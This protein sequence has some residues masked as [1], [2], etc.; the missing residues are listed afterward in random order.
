MRNV[1]DFLDAITEYFGRMVSWLALFMVLM[2]FTT[3]VLRYAYGISNVAMI[4]TIIY[5][6]AILFS[7]SAGWTLLRD[8]HVRVDIFYTAMTPRGKALVDL[9]GAAF[10]LFP[11]LYV[12]WARGIPYVARS[13][14]L[15]ETSNE[16]AGLDYLYVLKGFILVFA[17]VMTVQGISFT[18]RNIHTVIHGT[19]MHTRFGPKG[20]DS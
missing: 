2:S 10:F 17:A 13:W 6:F 1:V 18:L 9:C 16:V 11:V 20:N 14:A 4:E 8:E 12:V 7:A 15:G 5:A 19:P 3:V